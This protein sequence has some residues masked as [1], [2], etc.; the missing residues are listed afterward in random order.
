MKDQS[1]PNYQRR[2]G[3]H[4]IALRRNVLLTFVCF[5]LTGTAINAKS[6]QLGSSREVQRIK[7]QIKTG[8]GILQAIAGGETHS[9]DIPLTAG[10][11]LYLIIDQQGINLHETLS[12]PGG[13]KLME[14]ENPYDIQGQ[15]PVII[16]IVAEKSGSYELQV[17]AKLK[18]AKGYYELRSEETRQASGKDLD[19]VRAAQ[20]LCDAYQILV[21]GP[22]NSAT[23]KKGRELYL[24]ALPLFEAADDIY[25]RALILNHVGN[26][27]IWAEDYQKAIEYLNTSLELWRSTGD[28][29]REC[30]TFIALSRAYEDSDE[31]EKALEYS[32]RAIA[33]TRSLDDRGWEANILIDKARL[34]QFSDQYQNAINCHFQELT[35]RRELGQK[36]G[37]ANA[38]NNIGAL[39]FSLGEYQGALDYYNQALP[40]WREIGDRQ[41]EGMLLH[42]VAQ[43]HRFMGQNQKALEGFTRSLEI[44]QSLTKPVLIINLLNRLGEM[45]EILGENQ[46]ALTFYNQMLALALG[47]SSNAA[48][49]L[50]AIARLSAAEGKKEKAQDHLK[51][52]LP[53]IETIPWRNHHAEKYR[54]VGKIYQT[55]GEHEQ[56]LI[57]FNKALEIDRSLALRGVEG[58]TLSYIAETECRLGRLDSAL[59]HIEES[60]RIVESIRSAVTLQ[61]LRASYLSLVRK[62]YEIYIEILMRLD[63]ERPKEG[64]AF[65]ALDVSERARARV[66]LELLGESRVEIRQGVDPQLI[67]RE[68]E[69]K[70]ALNSKASNQSELLM[71][72]SAPDQLTSIGREIGMLNNEYQQVE[73][74]IRSKSPRYAALTQLMPLHSAEIQKQVLDPSTVLL[75]FALGHERSYLWAVTPTAINSFEL[76]KRAEIEVLARQAY[77]L[78]TARNQRPNG[79]SIQQYQM[80]VAQADAEY[81]RVATHLGDILLGPVS[82]IIADKRLII[83]TEG[84]LQYLPFSALPAPAGQNNVRD[85]QPLI[86]EHEIL[87]LPSA[88]VLGLMRRDLSGRKP[89]AGSVAVLADPVF[90]ADDP[91]V[92]SRSMTRQDSTP[93]VLNGNLTP[94]LRDAGLMNERG[95][96]SR[97]PFTREEAEGI[98]AASSGGEAIKAVDFKASLASVE[99]RELSRYRIV[100]FATHGILNTERPAL[101]GLVMSLVD[102]QGQQVDGYLRLNEIYNLNLPAELIVLSACQTALGKEINGEGLVGLTQGFMYA[103]AKRVLASVWKVNDSG[104]AE[105]MK[106]FY[107]EM[108]QNGKTPSSALR[109]TQVKMLQEKQWRAPYYWAA[110]VLQGEYK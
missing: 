37:E 22:G 42:N 61:E 11:F 109:A 82:N 70:N 54:G 87:S 34:F 90:S 16:S 103:G 66:L 15:G 17:Q 20:I 98:L 3:I 6:S 56:A 46:E 13:V 67:K 24:S 58:E 101:S 74:E 26:L 5:L 44:L 75:E 72:K 21:Q 79:E 78:L 69:L 1:R 93:R 39:Y 19:R 41:Q 25:G 63:K 83:V 29:R 33:L 55:L 104:T 96:L 73:S 105:M 53:F 51:Q 23:Y 80:R 110:F 102:E 49:A 64:F 68:R 108:L 57:F 38:L 94:G 95:T 65:R 47:Q 12:D 91:R 28:K 76:P 77:N 99:S 45:H 106:R 84:A 14:L 8:R 40:M 36:R 2:S 43:C 59:T 27:S 85:W 30:S 60:L 10:Q 35:L 9:Y 31:R 97:L 89:A 62:Y 86:A 81:Q 50:I 32:D 71:A 100:H 107:E 48:D 52:A 18:G 7:R 4:G 88:S 92:K